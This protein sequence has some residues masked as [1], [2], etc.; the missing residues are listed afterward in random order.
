MA[1]TPWSIGCN[2]DVV[3]GGRNVT[4]TFSFMV[5]NDSRCHGAL[6]KI[7]NALSLGLVSLKYSSGVGQK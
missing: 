3:I 1:I 5:F 4:S 2:N 7:N 6:S